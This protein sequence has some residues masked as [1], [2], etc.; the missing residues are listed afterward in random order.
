VLCVVVLPSNINTRYGHFIVGYQFNVGEIT[1]VGVCN[2]L[3]SR[4]PL[5]EPDLV[6]GLVCL[7]CCRGDTQERGDFILSF[8]PL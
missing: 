2:Y 4:S 5:S 6:F 8:S 1:Q 7:F 3:Y